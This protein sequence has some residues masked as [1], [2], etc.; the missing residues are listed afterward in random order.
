MTLLQRDLIGEEYLKQAS[1]TLTYIKTVWATAPIGA[2]LKSSN[3][4]FVR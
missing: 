1:S 2:K 4:G 3:G